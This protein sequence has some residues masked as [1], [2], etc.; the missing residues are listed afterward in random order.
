MNSV[1]HHPHLI[2]KQL[3]HSSATIQNF[4]VSSFLNKYIII[5]KL[6]G[7]FFQ[8]GRTEGF[9]HNGAGTPST[10][11]PAAAGGQRAQPGPDAAHPGR[12]ARPGPR[13]FTADGEGPQSSVERPQERV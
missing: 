9:E 2:S 12:A 4:S 11:S 13:Q 3:K 6:V 10:N 8:I 5:I 1:F 7:H